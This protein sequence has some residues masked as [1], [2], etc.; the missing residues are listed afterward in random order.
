MA[1]RALLFGRSLSQRM[2]QEGASVMLKYAL[3]FPRDVVLIGWQAWNAGLFSRSSVQTVGDTCWSRRDEVIPLP[4]VSAIAEPRQA[5]QHWARSHLRAQE[6][7]HKRVS[8]ACGG[9]GHLVAFRQAGVYHP[10]RVCCHIPGADLDCVCT[11][12]V[13][14]VSC[15]AKQNTRAYLMTSMWEAIALELGRSAEKR[16]T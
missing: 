8:A 10:P 7:L 9:D 13:G 11:V 16:A 15:S 6:V 1:G 3:I 2:P 12:Q 4:L 14:I 5:A